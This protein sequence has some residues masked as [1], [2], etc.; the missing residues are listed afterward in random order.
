MVQAKGITGEQLRKRAEDIAV[1]LATKLKDPK[2]VSGAIQD[3]E[4]FILHNGV[5]HYPWEPLSLSHGYPAMCVAMAE[6]DDFRR[7]SGWDLAGHDYVLGIKEEIEKHGIHS[8]SMW[9]GLAGILLGIQA[10]SKGGTR[11]KGFI[12]QLIDFFCEMY[13]A[14]L[15]KTMAKTDLGMSDYDVIEGWCSTIGILLIFKE[16]EWAKT[17]LVKI[18]SYLVLLSEDKEVMGIMVPGWCISADPSSSDS[19]PMAKFNCG[20]SHGIAGVLA[21]MAICLK[22]GIQIPGQRDAMHKISD[23]LCSHTRYDEYG[24]MFPSIISWEEEVNKDR[25]K[26]EDYHRDAWCYGS[27]GAA[28]AMWLA[29][30]GLHRDD[31]KE[32]ALDAFL[33]T[34]SKPMK[35]WNIYS[36]T[37]CHGFS[38]LLRLTHLMY[39]DSGNE[40]LRL[41]RDKLLN[42][43]VDMYDQ[44]A[45]LGFYDHNFSD[46]A[47]KKIV[48]LGMLEGV[49]GILLTVISIYR[50]P[51]TSWDLAFM[52]NN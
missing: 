10:L 52:I 11:Y 45:P 38:G 47:E 12:N 29:G 2:T 39:Q 34:F 51:V 43:I 5:K 25:S 20:M 17:A 15:E 41:E 30:E 46:N 8:L 33:A 13:P 23:W 26:S 37:F 18:L 7:S 50:K 3:K 31:L 42:M 28:R 16:E 27:P 4:N 14:E 32:I 19:G 48:N 9:S 21:A 40:T 1:E 6:M 22:E 44:D 35:K 24:V 36:P 49:A